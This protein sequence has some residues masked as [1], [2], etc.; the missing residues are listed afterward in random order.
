MR[1]SGVTSS[2]IMFWLKH[3]V[4]CEQYLVG[5]KDTVLGIL[6]KHLLFLQG[7]DG[8]H[9]SF[10]Y[11][12]FSLCGLEDGFQ[13]LLFTFS[14]FLM[15]RPIIKPFWVKCRLQTGDFLTEPCSATCK[16]TNHVLNHVRLSG[17]IFKLSWAIFRQP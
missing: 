8:K 5:C 13:N 7:T 1:S 16:R 15:H 4:I 12:A 14:Y 17:P 6:D 9:F 2:K 11:M 3:C 10:Y